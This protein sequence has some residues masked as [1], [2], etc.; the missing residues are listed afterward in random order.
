VTAQGIEARDPD[1]V[2]RLLVAGEVWFINQFYGLFMF[3]YVYVEP[4]RVAMVLGR[5][6]APK[7]R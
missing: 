6:P 3:D 1:F 4:L 7:D 2:D 5:K